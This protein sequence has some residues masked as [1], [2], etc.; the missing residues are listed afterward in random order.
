MHP[1]PGVVC[2]FIRATRPC[3]G[4]FERGIAFLLAEQKTGVR[5]RCGARKRM[6]I[7]RGK[8]QKR[9]TTWH[10][11]RIVRERCTG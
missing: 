5:G 10:L 4:H 8:R 2:R 7:L 11:M 1:G 6:A 3:G 9:S